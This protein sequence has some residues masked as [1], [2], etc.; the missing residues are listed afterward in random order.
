MYRVFPE[1]TVFM[2]SAVYEISTLKAE[3]SESTHEGKGS[4]IKIRVCFLFFGAYPEVCLG[5]Y[6]KNW[7]RDKKCKFHN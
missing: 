6:K 7:K 2:K 4:L 1:G 5:R 3:L